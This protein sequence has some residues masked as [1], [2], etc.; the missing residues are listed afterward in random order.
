M[1]QT[2]EGALKETDSILQRMH[3]LSAQAA[4]DTNISSKAD[5][6]I[7]LFA[8]DGSDPKSVAKKVGFNDHKDLA[9]FMKR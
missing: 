5:L 3:E 9:D 4:N 8:D 6:I 2:A 1:I 7:S